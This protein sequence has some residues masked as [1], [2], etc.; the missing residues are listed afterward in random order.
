MSDN[1]GWALW[2]TGLP[3]SGKTTLAGALRQQLAD[4]GVE[5]IILNSDEVRGVLTPNPTY[6]DEER[7][8]FY[9]DLVDLA[10]VL[11]CQGANVII[12]ATG[13]RR[14]YREAAR[15]HLSPFA[16]VWVRCPID[17]C[18]A[19]D[20]KGLYARAD[21][22]EIDSLPG[23]SVPYE[24]PEKP[25]VIVDTDHLT[26]EA[27]ARKVLAAIPF[28]RRSVE[29]R[30][31]L[32]SQV[33]TH[34]PGT[35]QP[36]DPLASVTVTPDTPVVEAVQ[37]MVDHGSDALPVVADGRLVGIVTIRDVLGWLDRKKC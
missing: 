35:A 13:S 34:N 36:G 9:M 3:A 2:L 37:L 16:E 1:R 32:V 23:V 27:S 11:T 14:D 5:A 8:R 28:L 17:V 31:F 24:P 20:P 7:D 4:L 22:G 12:A 33:M 19:R 29:R 25:A 30:P 15:K 18:R 6:K 26:A 10:R 21:A